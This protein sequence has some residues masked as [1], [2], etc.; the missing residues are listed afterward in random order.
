MTMEERAELDE[1]RERRAV[2]FSI[3]KKLEMGEKKLNEQCPK[4][5][6]NGLTV[7]RTRKYEY[8]S[9]AQIQADCRFCGYSLLSK[10]KISEK[11]RNHRTA[12]LA[13]EEIKK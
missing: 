13:Y 3:A 8:C 2:I 12:H 4:C 7:I 5:K 11:I 6:N 9:G 10:T 1:R